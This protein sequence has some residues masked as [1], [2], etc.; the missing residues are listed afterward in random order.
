[1]VDSIKMLSAA[2]AYRDAVTRQ[3]DASTAMPLDLTQK[4]GAASPSFSDLV[5]KTIDDAMAVA[6]KAE[7]TGTQAM[8]N[9][10][11]LDDLAV[12]VS[13]AELTLKAIVALRDRVVS[14]YQDIMKMPI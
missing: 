5:G 6:N 7:V 2:N 9:K 3:V 10:V 4:A 14:A 12:A 8:M 13:N 11:S 1:M